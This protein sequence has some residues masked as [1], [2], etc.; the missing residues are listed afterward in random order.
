MQLKNLFETIKIVK[1]DFVYSLC[2]RESSA[3]LLLSLL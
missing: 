3:P 1:V 2:D